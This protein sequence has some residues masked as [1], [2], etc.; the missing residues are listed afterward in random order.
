MFKECSNDLAALTLSH[1]A[2][3]GAEQASEVKLLPS[4]KT[5]TE[6]SFFKLRSL[7]RRRCIFLGHNGLRMFRTYAAVRPVSRRVMRR[8]RA[9]HL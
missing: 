8:I 1:L 3:S 2:W 6:S 4:H 9:L 5:D 7:R